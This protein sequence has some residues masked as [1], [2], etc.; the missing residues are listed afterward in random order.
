MGLRYLRLRPDQTPPQ[1][2]I[3]PFRAIIISEIE[4]AQ[5]WCNG[6]AEWL[7]ES[8]CLYVVAWGVDC[9]NW[10]DTVDWTIVETFAGGDIPD[11]KFVMTTWHTSDTLPETLWFAGQCASHPDVDLHETVILHVASESKEAEMLDTYS[12]SQMIDDE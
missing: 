11:D 8:G 5:S 12:K 6:V 1:L 7:L 2:T 10:H 3:G 9:E 4:V